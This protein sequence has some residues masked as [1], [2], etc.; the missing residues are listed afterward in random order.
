ME[1]EADKNYYTETRFAE[2]ELCILN[3]VKGCIESILEKISTNTTVAF[4]G[5]FK[6]VICFESRP[7]SCAEKSLVVWKAQAFYHVIHTGY[8][9][10]G[11]YSTNKK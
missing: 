1:V 7:N 3:S 8:W 9:K 4:S 2:F 11:R 10:I 6:C 5:L